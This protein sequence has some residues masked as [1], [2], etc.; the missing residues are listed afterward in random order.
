MIYEPSAELIEAL[1]KEKSALMKKALSKDTY[2]EAIDYLQC[3]SNE[4]AASL[5][6][7][8]YPWSLQ[9]TMTELSKEC[10][11][12][13]KQSVLSAKISSTQE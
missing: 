3:V 13:I 10:G 4:Y 7:T 9:R 5:A 11:E 2:K 1:K 6:A 8:K 12:E